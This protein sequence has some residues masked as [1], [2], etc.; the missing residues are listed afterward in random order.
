MAWEE[1]RDPVTNHLLARID[2]RRHLLELQRKKSVHLVDLIPYLQDN[3]TQ[4]PVE[5]I[6]QP[7]Q[8]T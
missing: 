2:P 3:G 1:I 7:Q 5:A 6:E 4:P 8:E